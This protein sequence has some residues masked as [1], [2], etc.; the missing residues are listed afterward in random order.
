MSKCASVHMLVLAQNEHVRG[1]CC[2]SLRSLCRRYG[3]GSKCR[4]ACALYMADGLS[5][6]NRYEAGRKV[7]LASGCVVADMVRRCDDT[8]CCCIN[9]LNCCVIAVCTRFLVHS[10]GCGNR[11]PK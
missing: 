5:S 7:S 11:S 4:R 9:I 1:I 6:C 3:I 2:G 8:C 10:D